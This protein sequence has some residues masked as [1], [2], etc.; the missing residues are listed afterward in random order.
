MLALDWLDVVHKFC[1]EKRDGT[2]V[3]LVDYPGYGANAGE[4]NEEAIYRTAIGAVSRAWATEPHVPR[5]WKP[6]PCKRPACHL[7]PPRLLGVAGH[8]PARARVP[9]RYRWRRTP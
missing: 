6:T 9:R 7:L 5:R 3:V 2:A 1:D 4:P 8:L